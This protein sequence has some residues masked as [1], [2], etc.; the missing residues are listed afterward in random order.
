MGSG[1]VN[2][3]VFLLNRSIG[4][5]AILAVAIGTNDARAGQCVAE[6]LIQLEA[7]DGEEGDQFGI[8]VAVSGSRMVVGAN[9]ANTAYVFFWEGSTW[10]Q[11]D[12]LTA[13][14]SSFGD[15][16]GQA[17]SIEGDLIVVGAPYDDNQAVDSGSAY[18]FRLGDDGWV[19]E[20]KLVAPD[21]GFG[22]IFGRSVAISGDVILVGAER[23]DDQAENAGSAYVFRLAG[24]QWVLEQKLEP[25]FVVPDAAFGTSVAV[26]GDTAMVA[27]PGAWHVAVFG[28]DGS[29]WVQEQTITISILGDSIAIAGDV[30]VFG[31]FS[32]VGPG[33]AFVYRYDGS[34]WVQETLLTPGDP[35]FYLQFGKTVAI[36]CNAIAVGAPGASA[37]YVFNHAAE[38]WF[39]VAKLVPSNGPSA[40]IGRAVDISGGWVTAGLSTQNQAQGSVYIFDSD[41][42]QVSPDLNDDG[43]VDAHDLALLLGSWGV[44][45]GC[46][47]DYNGDGEVNTADLAAL[48]AGWSSCSP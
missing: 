18:V 5:L 31:S 23:D 8:G 27:S 33:V 15:S 28:Y 10:S 3:P 45:P 1:A 11:V 30:A 12:V 24:E 32:P 19:E 40:H 2:H 48:L 21:G 46:P 7:L 4:V 20:Q 26:H 41:P 42:C 29:E 14:E 43:P 35:D 22:D 44:C 16:F 17:V 34:S 25:S 36:E 39:E 38:D 13:S 37:V 6:E 9:L 47:A